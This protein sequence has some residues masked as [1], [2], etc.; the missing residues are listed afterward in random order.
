MQKSVD[1][2]A[3]GYDA[4][5]DGVA[6]ESPSTV[7]R[8]SV[9]PHER[10]GE[11]DDAQASTISFYDDN[12]RD[13]FQKT[14]DL[15]MG[16]LYAPFLRLLPPGT[17]ILDAGCGSGRDSLHF[18]N[19]GFAVTAFDASN[20]MARMAAGLIGQPVLRLSFRD[21]DFV[22]R[23]D[24]VWANASLLHVSRDEIDESVRRLGRS[25]KAGGV[26][27]ASFRY[28]NGEAFRGGR[29]FNDYT[30]EAVRTMFAEYPNLG[31]EGVWK[32]PDLRPDAS[33]KKVW[34][35]VIVR[36]T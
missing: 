19:N 20:E 10:Y 14:R 3:V 2:V 32:T 4:Q 5:S 24:G 12:A 27:F 22:E 35:N 1:P 28:G 7:G 31:V 23:F 17:H 21:V 13:F 34:L 15:D 25:L 16:A 26:L 11:V 8:T 6:A 9:T 33:K 18:L 36:K 29:L 30:E